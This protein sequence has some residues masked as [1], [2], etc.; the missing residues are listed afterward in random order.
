[1]MELFILESHY[2]LHRPCVIAASAMFLALYTT[3]ANPW[4]LELETAC[5]LTVEDVQMCVRA[6]HAAYLRMTPNGIIPAQGA[7]PLVALRDKFSHAKFDR[8]AE[9]QPRLL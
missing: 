9:I 3:H 6:M 8:V 2:L 1:M 7:P 4:P 5:Q